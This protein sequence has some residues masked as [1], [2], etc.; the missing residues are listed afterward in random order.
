MEQ[1]VA[2]TFG[3]QWRTPAIGDLLFSD[4]HDTH[5]NKS[6][7]NLQFQVSWKLGNL[8]PSIG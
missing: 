6:L 3:D 2:F 1:I 4:N 5:N 7:E 8:D